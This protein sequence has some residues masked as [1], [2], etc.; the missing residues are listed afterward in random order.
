MYSNFT[1]NDVNE[2]LPRLSSILRQSPELSSRAGNVRE[3]TMT[4]ITL[5]NPSARYILL[6]ARKASLAA[7]IAE[8]M[9]VLAG[10][11]DVAWLSHYLP[12][13]P[14][15]SDDGAT[16]RGAY[17]KRLRAWPTAGG[18]R[19][20]LAWVVDHLRENRSSRRATLAIFNPA[21]DQEDGL[22]DVPCNDILDF[23]S[24]DGYLDL[25]VMT[26]SND[27]I[28]GWSGINQFEWSVLLEI[29]ST[30]LGVT[31]GSVHFS[32]SSLHAYDRH[33]AL[34]DDL[35]KAAVPPVAERLQTVKFNPP[36]KS[37]AYLDGLIARWFD[38]EGR[39]RQA[40]GRT[41]DVQAF[42]EEIDRFP[43]P[44]FRSWLYVLLA[45]WSGDEKPL[46]RVY[47]SSTTLSR[48]IAASVRRTPREEAPRPAADGFVAY[49]SN[50]HETKDAAYGDSW[51]RR[52]ERVGILANI[53]RKVDRLGKTDDTETAADTAIDLL[54]YLMKY[55]WWLFDEGRMGAPLPAAGLTSDVKCVNAYLAELSRNPGWAVRE[56]YESDLSRQFD[57]LL[58]QVE[59]SGANAGTL[60]K[61]IRDAHALARR[62]FWKA[63][64]EKRS[65]KGYGE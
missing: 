8:T 65:W 23:K 45:W 18:P 44:L 63:N 41:D 49:V 25:H 22:K 42:L 32:I 27:L 55:R 62:E 31:P 39:I 47:R 15:F 7:Q 30:M 12:R 37:I 13:A 11:D 29:V 24:R 5:T 10:R 51:K 19:D 1:F 54:V 60:N 46:E 17:G 16:W 26:R 58:A 9:W 48:A 34:L 59:A 21:T 38:I 57:N 53:A 40:A 35:S 28:W 33:W 14:Q 61:M 43:E 52:G 64:N 50:L 36:A 20:Q 3:M 56:D 6:P 2:A 4:S